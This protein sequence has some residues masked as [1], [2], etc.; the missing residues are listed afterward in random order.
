MQQVVPAAALHKLHLALTA[1]G[2]AGESGGVG[3]GGGMAIAMADGYRPSP[4]LQEVM[5]VLE[6]TKGCCVEISTAFNLNLPSKSNNN[7]DDEDDNGRKNSDNPTA[8]NTV[9]PQASQPWLEAQEAKNLPL[10]PLAHAAEQAM[11][12]QPNGN[13]DGR[14][15]GSKNNDSSSNGRDEGDGEAERLRAREKILSDSLFREFD[16][17]TRTRPYQDMLAKRS[18]LPAYEMRDH[19]VR[20]VRNAQVVV[21]SGETGCGKTT[22]VPQLVLDTMIMEKEGAS[23]NIIVTQPRRISAVGVAERIAAERAERIGETA[24]Y[25]IRLESKRSKATRLLLCTTGILLRRLQVDPWL[26]SVSH[27][28]VDEV[29]ERDLDTDFLLI[30]LKGLLAKRPGLKLV[31]MSATLNADMFSDFFG[32][33]PVVEIP[34]RAH[35]VTPFFLEDV[36]E[37]T[38][39]VVDPKG[40]F[41]VKGSK[42]GGGGGGGGG[43]RVSGMKPGD[44]ECPSCGNNCF[45]SKSACYRC[46]TAK[47]TPGGAKPKGKNGSRNGPQNA[48]S[49]AGQG[50]GAG[51]G[52]GS[53]GGGAERPTIGEIKNRYAG[54]SDHVHQSLLVVDESMINYEAISSLLEYITYNF[55]EGAILVFLPGLA[56]ITK[57]LEAL[58]GN[59]LF[60]DKEKTRVYPLHGS[61]STSDQKAIFEVPPKGVRK[62]VV[63][64]NIAETS[65]TIEDCVFVVDSCKVKGTIMT[66][67]QSCSREN[68]FDDANMMPMLL[69]CWVSKASAK[70][71]RGR[72]G[73]VRPGVCFHMCSSGTFQDT[74]SEF[75]LPEM[76]RVSL[77]DMVLQILLLDKGDPAEFLASAV[78]PPTELAVA[79]SIKYLCELQATQLDEDDKPVLTA[80]GFHLA[81]LPVEPRVGKMMLYGAI[82]GC[83]EPAI[84]IAA[85][86]SCRNPFVAPFD[87]YAVFFVSGE[88]KGCCVI[89]F[90]LVGF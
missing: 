19:I 9:I 68:R 30:I 73:R 58:A 80:L 71:R 75:Q 56:E 50:A 62:I 85:A 21:V 69:E 89:V 76:L 87:K 43:G 79:N 29:H 52:G 23:A 47:P 78:N 25:Q 10:P 44:W 51:S 72:A 90:A 35:P 27:V 83:V 18:K 49:T 4:Y 5:E 24:G 77:D 33:A 42:G 67:K 1:D 16:K 22:Q 84:T 37:R 88:S 38:G 31:L 82:F 70:Q 36:L 6:D 86:M 13:G 48:P 54:F 63:S 11:Q 8:A 46:G 60:N 39:Y 66:Q 57:M 14:A 17:K 26:A 32:G 41:A 28:F 40:D 3:G 2:G 45:A 81:T 20:T 59:P 15:A 34:G 7:N 55:E 12:A 64:T 53:V 61:L 65:I 74:I